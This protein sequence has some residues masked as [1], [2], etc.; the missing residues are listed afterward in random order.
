[1]NEVH[2]ELADEID[3]LRAEVTEAIAVIEE[4]LKYGQHDGSCT[5]ADDDDGACVRHLAA[6]ARRQAAA[7]TFL[8]RVTP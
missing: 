8:A 2:T 6:S 3:R 5:N 7:E 4:L 1:V